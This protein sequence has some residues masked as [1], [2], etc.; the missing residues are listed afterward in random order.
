MLISLVTAAE[1]QHMVCTA[2]GAIKGNDSGG[3]SSPASWWAKGFFY[4]SKLI[5]AALFIAAT[6][7]PPFLTL[8]YGW[9]WA[10]ALSLTGVLLLGSFLT[11]QCS[12]MWTDTAATLAVTV[13]L[14]K[15]R[16]FIAN[17]H[18][19]K[20]ILHPFRNAIP[21]AGPT[22]VEAPEKASSPPPPEQPA[23]ADISLPAGEA[24]P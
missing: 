8:V 3:E 19:P 17:P 13:G 1:M 21:W 9:Y 22:T 6:I 7:V 18:D 4:L 16:R 2:S 12:R 15:G 11:F 14:L 20:S 5:G 10:E 24:L 23:P